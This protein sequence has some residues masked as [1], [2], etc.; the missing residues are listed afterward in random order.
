MSQW[1]P[2]ALK[3]L[4]S[5]ELIRSSFPKLSVHPA[6]DGY[7]TLLRAGEGEWGEEPP[8]LHHYP[9][10]LTLQQPLPY[11]ANG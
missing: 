1:W 11:T 8:Q 3:G 2:L 5:R 9:H 7:P 6:G 10:N 4:G